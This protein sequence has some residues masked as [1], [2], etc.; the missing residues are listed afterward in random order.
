MIRN[1]MTNPKAGDVIRWQGEDRWY[2]TLVTEVEEI[3]SGEEVRTIVRWVDVNPNGYSDPEN[4][5]IEEWPHEGI[6]SG[7]VLF[8][9]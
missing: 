9:V 3:G 2:V 4:T 1:P 7:T 6:K 8:A 5:D